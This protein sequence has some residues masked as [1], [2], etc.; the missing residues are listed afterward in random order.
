MVGAAL[1][2]DACDVVVDAEGF[3]VRVQAVREP[4]AFAEDSAHELI[5]GVEALV[6]DCLDGP[7]ETSD[8]AALWLARGAY[9]I[10]RP[11]G[12]LAVAEIR[13]TWA[14]VVGSSWAYDDIYGPQVLEGF[15][16]V[17]S[18][19]LPKGTLDVSFPPDVRP[20][21]VYLNGDKLDRIGP[22]VMP[23][24]MHLLQ[25]KVGEDWRSTLVPLRENSRITVGG[26][27]PTEAATQQKKSS[28]YVAYDRKKDRESGVSVAGF[29]GYGGT[30]NWVNDGTTGY[31]GLTLAP[32]IRLEVKALAVDVL[33]VRLV[34]GWT[35]GVMAGQAPVM[36]RAG[37]LVGV[38]LGTSTGVDVQAGGAVAALPGVSTGDGEPEFESSLGFG[39]QVRIDGF[40]GPAMV[41][42]AGTWYLDAVGID[43]GVNGEVRRL[44]RGG[45]VPL[46][47]LN[48]AWL[49]TPADASA[50][51]S[52]LAL[53]AEVGVRWSP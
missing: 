46:L 45:L 33:R 23:A 53:I 41:T 15:E 22:L 6:P 44:A 50:R 20:T 35:P 17:S 1:A 14:Y 49:N 11:G 10:L 48:A 8:L 19:L 27:P 36:T 37:L 32:A 16:A 52:Y 13:L 42:V 9:E 40:L 31:V 5:R 47:G 30:Q 3:K 26:G 18:Q 43:V 39:P 4:V 34:G 38:H 24:G 21:E 29:A 28:A 51:D 2:Q 25:W 7:V 12:D